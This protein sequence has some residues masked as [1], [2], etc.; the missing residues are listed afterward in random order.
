MKEITHSTFSHVQNIKVKQEVK[1][2][3]KPQVHQLRY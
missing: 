2:H 1:I 3:H